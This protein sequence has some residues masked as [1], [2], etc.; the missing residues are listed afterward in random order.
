MDEHLVIG[1]DLGATKIASVL[2]DSRGQV[3]KER[4]ALTGAD[5]GAQA[6]IARMAGEILALLADCPDSISGIGIGVP[7]YV[8]PDQ[9]MVIDA[10]NLDWYQVPLLDELKRALIRQ[11]G[12]AAVPPLWMQMDTFA[13]ALGEYYFGAARGS[14]DLLYLSIGSGFSAGMIAAGRLIT[15]ARNLAGQCG[16]YSLGRNVA[17]PTG[18]QPDDTAEEVLSGYGLLAQTRRLLMEGGYLTHL[19]ES[20]ALNTTMI[21]EAARQGD[22]LAAAVMDSAGLTLAMVVAP[23]LSVLNPSALVIGGGLGVAAFDLLVP[24]MMAELNKRVIDAYLNPLL[25]APSGLTSSAIGAGCLVF[26]R[27][28]PEKFSL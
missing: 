27:T 25:V 1:I 20:A 14:Q 23:Y 6:V 13:S 19:T 9:G 10:T 3:L 26:R 22:P 4:R 7:G 21:L 2:M 24:R 11:S 12:W 17:A 18:L 8:D 5:Q 28:L 15:G 16:Y